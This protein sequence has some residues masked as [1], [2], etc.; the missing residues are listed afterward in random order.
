MLSML[1]AEFHEYMTKHYVTEVTTYIDPLKIEKVIFNPPA[2]IIMW[3]DR[4]KTVVQCQGGEPFD[5]EKGMTMAFMKKVCGNTGAYFK[6]INKWCGPYY[7]KEVES[8][9]PDLLE[10]LSGLRDKAKEFNDNFRDK[11]YELKE[12]LSALKA[13]DTNDK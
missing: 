11:F 5:P 10:N 1:S 3:A 8:L 2:T 6:E 7:E 13:S 4:T 9:Y 12:T